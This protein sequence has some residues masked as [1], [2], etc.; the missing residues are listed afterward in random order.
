MN[1]I[2]NTRI[3]LSDV[4]KSEAQHIFGKNWN[5]NFFGRVII[6]DSGTPID[7]QWQEWSNMYPDLFDANISDTDMLGE[8]YDIIGTLQDASETI[9]EYDAEEQA[10]WLANEI[11]NQYWNVSPVRTIADKYDKQ[12][13][14]LNFEHR[15][16]MAELR[17]KYNARLDKR[18]KEQRKADKDRYNELV[19]KIRERK[20][21][22]IALAKQHGKDMMSKYKENAERKTVIQSILSTTTSLNKKLLKNDK[23]VHIP[24]SLKPVVINLIN[25]I[26]FSSK[27]L[28]GMDGS[29]R[30]RRGTPTKAD[31]ALEKTFGKVKSMADDGVTLKQSIQETLKMFQNAEKVANNTADGTM[32]L[33][34]VSLDVDL[35]DS[36]E[37]LITG[38]DVLEKNYGDTFA[39][40]QMEFDHLK[41]LNATVKSISVWASNVDRALS[42][43][44]KARISQLGEE[45]IY[46]NDALGERQEY[47]KA[48]ES[49]KQFFSWSNLLPVNAFKR[50]GKSA[51]KVF[52]LVRDAQDDLT[53]HQDEIT[54]FTEKLFEG[55]DVNKWRKDIKE[56]K[57]NLPNG[58]TKTVRMPVSYIMTLYC[59]SKQEDAQRHLYG[60]DE[61]GNR[62]DGGGMTIA[63]FQ[64]NRSLKVSKDKDNTI[65]TEGLV[66]QITS[67]LT[68]EQRDIADKLQEFMNTKGS[69]WCDSVSMALY[70]IKKFD[71]ENYFPI[72]VTPTTIKVLDPQDKRQSIH[73]FSILNYG[74]TKS[75]NPDAKQSIE[76][77][78]VFEI[79]ANHMSMAAIYSSY[80]LPIYDMVRWYNYKGK[81]DS[82]KEIGVIQSIQKAFG[83]S[84]TTYIGRLISDLNGQHESS[85][86]GFVTKIFQNTKLA[87]VGN[88]ISVSLLQPTAYFK[89]MTKIPTRYLLKSLLYVKDFGVKKGVEKSKK[90]CGIALWKSKGNFD[91]DISVDVKTQMMH[92]EKWHEK[93]KEW[94]LWLA[95]WMDERTWGVLWNACEF[96]IRAE[97]KD[98]KVGSDEFYEA[99][100]YKL[101]DVIYETQVVDS[102]LT[103]S[104][105]MRS[106]DTGAKMI[107]MFASE[108]TVAYNMVHEAMIDAHL[109]VKRYGKE[110]ALKRN[111]KNIA[112]TLTAY[113]LTSAISQILYTAVQ[114]FRDDDDEE[115]EFE[116][117][118]KMYLSNFVADWVIIGKIPYIKEILNYAQGYSSS[119]PDTLWLDSTS[120]AIKY[121][122]RAFDGKE[123][124]GEKAIKE[125]LKT[126]SYLSGLPMYNQYRDAMATLD[127]LGVLTAEDFEEMLDDLFN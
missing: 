100:A 86:L 52:D 124:A 12:I 21:K 63:P 103:R 60:V 123:G 19:K 126:M 59:V 119:R 82:G 54:T 127:K 117:Y 62:T 15:Q 7:T 66:K 93:V 38:I 25:A 83:D 125:S 113:T 49:L 85:R 32:D 112:M 72:T 75:R 26:D 115:K 64:E 45:T 34:L 104:D 96:E 61:Y 27:Q 18:L 43:K 40:Q 101:R 107:T 110:G 67:A 3:R 70:G 46:E 6:T 50:L 76:I 31:M 44:H 77:G 37:E 57:L 89:A 97:R 53:F 4:Q 1:D 36:I 105:L 78:D 84:A 80:A 94:S 74:F 55:H 48:V 35:I 68:K 13:K 91:N 87:M 51:M 39:L 90:Y 98:L 58:D 20:D 108:I 16:T 111:G 5:R 122:A 121:W 73:F 2:R 47:I 24:E 9:M 10:R 42:S 69:E 11:Y 56:F 17:E 14:K 81:T 23:D 65:M 102:P 118:L 8:L 109:D 33:S 41:T 116:D 99:I 114:A 95:G 120:K 22:E 79:F 71:V 28:L 106:P 92:D 30:D 88:S 29:R